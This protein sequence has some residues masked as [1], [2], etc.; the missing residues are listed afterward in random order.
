[1]EATINL[2]DKL[3]EWTVEFGDKKAEQL[4]RVVLREMKNYEYLREFKIQV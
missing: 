3:K 2:D 4:H 1:M